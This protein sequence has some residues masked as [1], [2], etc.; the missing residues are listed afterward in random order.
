MRRG[1]E[2]IKRILGC[3]LSLAL[4]AGG[5]PGPVEAEETAQ[6]GGRAEAGSY[7]AYLETYAGKNGADTIT[8]PAAERYQTDAEVHVETDYE[9]QKG[10]SL[11][12]PEGS[13]VTWSFDV[14]TEGLYTLCLRYFP[15]EGK[16]V[17]IERTVLINGVVPYAEAENLLFPRIW[18]NALDHVETDVYGNDIRPSQKENPIWQE[19]RAA[20]N[21]G[22]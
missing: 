5:I 19:K 16:G 20:D 2:W 22:D 10:Q 17:D 1:T 11:Y 21:H 18:S 12:T 4:F 14:E 7:A 6:S 15:V 8:I 13:S 9:G 3:M